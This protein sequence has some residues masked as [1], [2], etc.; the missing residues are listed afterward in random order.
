MITSKVAIELTRFCSTEESLLEYLRSMIQNNANESN[1]GMQQ[2]KV[3]I[4]V[5]E[6]IDEPKV[7]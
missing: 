3:W 1:I 2:F 5:Q 6:I 7:S 4:T